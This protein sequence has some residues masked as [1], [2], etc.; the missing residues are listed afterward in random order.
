MDTK[1]IYR[2]AERG[3]LEEHFNA[4]NTV[5]VLCSYF[6]DAPSPS[7]QQ[8]LE[9]AE[10]G[11]IANL[12]TK[13][14]VLVLPRPNEALAMKD[15]EGFKAETVD[16]GYELK[17][18]QVEM[19]LKALNIPNVSVAF[20]NAFEDGPERLSNFLLELVRSLR[21]RHCKKLEEAIEGANDLVQNF[22]R[23]QVLEIQQQA[24]KRLLIWIKNNQEIGP[25]SKHMKDSLLSAI[26]KAHPSSLRASVRRQGEWYNLDYSH[27]LGYGARSVAAGAVGAKI[28]GFKEIAKNLLQDQELQ[29]A[30]GLVQQA[31]RILESG[32]EDLFLKS[33]ILGR[34]IY[35]KYMRLDTQ[36]WNNCDGEWGKGSGYRNRVSGHHQDWFAD[37]SDN[38]KTQTQV[39]VKLHVKNEWKEILARIAGILEDKESD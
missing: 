20:F 34:T 28:E 33:Q 27:Q 4:P 19:R 8:L 35:T 38:I 1:G 18:D 36:L 31:Y 12:Q 25:I 21:K 32:T 17:E 9:R 37:V 29:E 15:D 23:E 13:V 6:N 30:F 39:I 26:S 24:A 16:E 5:V 7:A 10:K 11:R 14:A 22:A 2:I 3:D